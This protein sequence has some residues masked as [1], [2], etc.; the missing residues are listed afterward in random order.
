MYLEAFQIGTLT[1]VGV[2]V[3]AVPALA[4]ENKF[5]DYQTHYDLNPYGFLKTYN[6]PNQEEQKL[7]VRGSS[8]GINSVNSIIMLLCTPL[9]KV[10]AV[11]DRDI[12]EG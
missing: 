11:T 6:A 12:T 10:Y 3:G 5:M 8:D 4:Q 7:I 1:L 2:D 9:Q